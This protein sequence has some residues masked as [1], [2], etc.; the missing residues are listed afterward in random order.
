[1]PYAAFQAQES[2][3][4]AEPSAEVVESQELVL[5]PGQKYEVV[6]T[7]AAEVNYLAVVV[8]FRTPVPQRWRFIFDA[9][10][11]ADTGI[12]LGLHGCAASVAAGQALDMPLELTRVAGVRCDGAPA[13]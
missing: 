10:S 2:G 11:A 5:A 7:L 3:N 1:L 4:H 12:S 13:S 8:L 9:K 6:Q